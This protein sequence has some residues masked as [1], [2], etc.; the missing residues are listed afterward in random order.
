MVLHEFRESLAISDEVN[1]PSADYLLFER[2][3]NLKEGQRHTVNFIDFYDDSQIAASLDNDKGYL[4]YVSKYPLIPTDMIVADSFA[5]SG[6]GAA[7]P[8]VLFKAS[9][10]RV[11]GNPVLID[12]FPNQFLGSSPTFTF[13]SNHLYLTLILYDGA[14]GTPFDPQGVQ[15]SVYMAI[16]SVD[17]DA[18]EYSMGFWREYQNAQLI[19]LLNTA[20]VQPGTPALQAGKNFPM[21]LAGGIRPERVLRADALADW[22]HNLDGNFAE[23]TQTVTN[24]REFYDAAKTM[25]PFTTA[26]GTFD[27]SKGEIP[28]WI[29][30]NALPTV[31]GGEVRKEFP[32]AIM[33]TAADIA[34]GVNNV[35]VMV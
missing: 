20:S 21:W 18:V 4:F 10:M 30:V 26:F 5:N 12:E 9:V 2:R 17:V 13:Y 28:D 22:W 3:I 33:P 8:N 16:D 25:Q 15:M 1:V 11:E 23:K 14:G 29:R 24:L 34:A 27:A 7:D 31:I 35:Q 32:I 19:P 6:P